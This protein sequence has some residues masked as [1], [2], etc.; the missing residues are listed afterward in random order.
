M[1]KSLVNALH[2]WTFKKPILKSLENYNLK[3]SILIL[4]RYRIRLVSRI[5]GV[6]ISYGRSTYRK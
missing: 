2:L 1:K 3:F 4:Y 6:Q 5:Y